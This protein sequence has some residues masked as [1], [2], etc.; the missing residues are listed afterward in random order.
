MSIDKEEDTE[1]ELWRVMKLKINRQ[2]EENTMCRRRGK[3][4]SKANKCSR[5]VCAKDEGTGNREVSAYVCVCVLIIEVMDGGMERTMMWVRAAADEEGW[6]VC[7]A[8]GF[9]CECV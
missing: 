3:K 8:R 4:R 7:N 2:R 6:D 5:D 1:G 9:V